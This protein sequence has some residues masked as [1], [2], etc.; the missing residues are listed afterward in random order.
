MRPS[1]FGVPPPLRGGRG[2]S[3]DDDDDNDGHNFA[4][5]MAGSLFASNSAGDADA[6]AAADR[7]DGS[8]TWLWTKRTRAPKLPPP[9][10]FIYWWSLLL[11]PAPRGPEEEKDKE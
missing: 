4:D 10:L 3:D 2:K 1:L 5:K 8:A 9:R 6:D 11:L 7:G